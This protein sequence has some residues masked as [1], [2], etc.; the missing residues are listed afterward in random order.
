MCLTSKHQGMANIYGTE[1]G[2]AKVAAGRGE[3]GNFRSDWHFVTS[4]EVDDI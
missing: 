1:E 2:T 3:V 4:P